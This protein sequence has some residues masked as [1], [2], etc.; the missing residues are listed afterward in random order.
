[1][2]QTLILASTSPYRRELLARL[3]LPFQVANPQTDETPLPA[4][5]PEAMALRLSEAKA[6][7]VADSFPDA[8]IIGSDQVA[9]VDGK[10]YGKPGTHERAVD[11]LRNLSGKTV[12]FFTGLCLYNARTGQAEV[13]GIPTL[14]SFRHL[15]DSEI[16]NY[17][18]R[19]PAYNCA[20][21]AKSEGLGIALLSKMQGEDPNALVGLPLIAL[22]DLLRNQGLEILQ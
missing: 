13:R 19:E 22:C 17:L 4:E 10:I 7:A 6:R 18:R 11:Q 3:G 20:G 8:L 5:P 14:V 1:M 21:S 9:T 15:S 2:P 12:N 16:E